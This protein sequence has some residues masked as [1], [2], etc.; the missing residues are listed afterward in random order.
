MNKV[1]QA[2]TAIKYLLSKRQ[3]RVDEYNKRT[4]L[5]E[6]QR[7]YILEEVDFKTNINILIDEVK[8]DYQKT[9]GKLPP[10]DIELE[11]SVLGTI[12]FENPCFDKAKLFL[13][14]EHFYLKSHEL[15]W[16]A[17]LEYGK[18]QEVDS[19][20]VFGL[21]RKQGYAEEI[22]GLHYIASLTAKA[23]SAAN[24]ETWGRLL[25]EKAI[26][27]QLIF[28]AGRILDEAYRDESDCFDLL[29][30]AEDEVKK[31]NS[32]IK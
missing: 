24:I 32:W 23:G 14:P 28:A 20:G 1:D 19:I 16:A 25:I 21:L 13:R 18:T 12:I 7:Q 22:G 4:D 31:M 27:R 30:V 26:K 10:Q 5:T 3:R 2:I 11:K 29:A 9:L 6:A 15:I 17:A 8:T